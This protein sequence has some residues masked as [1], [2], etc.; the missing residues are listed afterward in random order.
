M[1][2]Q[3]CENSEALMF[4]E[5]NALEKLG[6]PSNIT[7]EELKT[8]K[9][10]VK[11]YESDEKTWFVYAGA[12]DNKA[13]QYD[14]VFNFKQLF[15]FKEK[16]A[17]YCIYIAQPQGKTQETPYGLL[18]ERIVLLKRALD[19]ENFLYGFFRNNPFYLIGNIKRKVKHAITTLELPPPNYEACFGDIPLL[20]EKINLN[21]PNIFE[22]LKMYFYHIYKTPDFNY[23]ISYQYHGTVEHI[24]PEILM[25]IKIFDCKNG[26]CLSYTCVYCKNI[27]CKIRACEFYDSKLLDS[28]VEQ[29]VHQ[30]ISK[31]IHH[32]SDYIWDF[33]V[34]EIMRGSDL[35]DRN[36]Y[37]SNE[38]QNLKCIFIPERYHHLLDPELVEYCRLDLQHSD[39]SVFDKLEYEIVEHHYWD[40]EAIRIVSEHKCETPQIT[41]YDAFA[42]QK[43]SMRYWAENVP[44]MFIAIFLLRLPVSLINLHFDKLCKTLARNVDDLP[45]NKLYKTIQKTQRLRFSNK[46]SSFSVEELIDCFCNHRRVILKRNSKP[47][48]PGGDIL[49]GPLQL[50]E[51]DYNADYITDDQLKAIKNSNIR[52]PRQPMSVYSWMRFL[53]LTTNDIFIILSDISKGKCFESDYA[54]QRLKEISDIYI[55]YGI[56]NK[57]AE[58]IKQGFIESELHYI[59][60]SFSHRDDKMDILRFINTLDP[61]LSKP[62]LESYVVERQRINHPLINNASIDE[63]VS[64]TKDFHKYVSHFCNKK[65]LL[66]TK[67]TNILLETELQIDPKNPDKN[68]IQAREMFANIIISFVNS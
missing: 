34:R 46:L 32:D 57:S 17:F 19:V 16:S 12:F 55:S 60:S 47:L 37:D 3:K 20:N 66:G 18:C 14:I 22:M 31:K 44:C 58:E 68:T 41:I 56:Y 11:L 64:I 35:N 9:A 59:Q 54:K 21:N 6:W 48:I 5:K 33:I 65:N 53:F 45:K 1:S 36:F 10:M 40:V 63:N 7:D 49:D 13:M 29:F 42:W 51:Y 23:R 61:K 43:T 15:R 50:D 4:E 52:F 38:M 28:I 8:I 27:K 24:P 26:S 25:L 39:Y 62:I 2:D 67:N 30:Q